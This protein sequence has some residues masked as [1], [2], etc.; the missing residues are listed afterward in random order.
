[1]QKSLTSTSIRRQLISFSSWMIDE[2]EQKM[3]RI[4]WDVYYRS[5][6]MNKDL[7]KERSFY[8]GRNDAACAGAF[9][10]NPCMFRHICE[11][12]NFEMKQAIKDLKYQRVPT[13]TPWSLDKEKKD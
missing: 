2:W 13:W 6:D 8:A 11:T 9:D 1:M 7:D 12:E 5:Y 3:L 10:S 4:F